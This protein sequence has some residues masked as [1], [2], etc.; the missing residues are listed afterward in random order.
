MFAAGFLS[1]HAC[2]PNPCL[3]T[4]SRLMGFK[5]WMLLHLRVL[6]DVCSTCLVWCATVL[7]HG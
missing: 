7:L 5:G 2:L 3:V 6:R 1:Q 4:C